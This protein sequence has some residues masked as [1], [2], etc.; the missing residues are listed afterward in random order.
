MSYPFNYC[1]MAVITNF[2]SL[3]FQL[4]EFIDFRL[5]EEKKI[6]SGNHKL[7]FKIVR[8]KPSLEPNNRTSKSA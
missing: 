8:D 5:L 2:K 3:Y 1:V 6:Q 4:C 7:Q